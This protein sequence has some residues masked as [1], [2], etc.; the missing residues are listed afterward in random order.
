MAASLKN[1]I[2]LVTGGASGIGRAT[3]L[4]LA[5]EGAKV[6]VADVQQDKAN[7]TVRLVEAVGGEAMAV[8]CD[9]S[10]AGQVEALV[11][12]CVSRH[13]R[14]DCGINVAGILGEMGKIHECTE[15]NYD[16]VMATNT[17]GIWLCMKYEIIQ[18]LAQGSGVIVNI[19]SVA[20]AAGTPDLAVYGAS[21][22]AITMLTRAAAVDLV[23]KNIRVNAINPG[24]VQTEMVDQQEVDYPDKVKEYRDS[25][26]I[27]RMG[28]PEEIAEAVVWLCSDK[29]SF[30]A[31]QVMN[32]DGAALA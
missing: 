15:E 28:R 19:A 17:K 31:G 30:V 5:R 4:L 12:A 26:R 21:K 6:V 20:G 11:Q 8:A 10:K 7:E 23:A 22:V 9:V 29:A 3:C 32:V 1:R 14:L 27:G 2:A 24:F 25:L 13:G 16:R 18:M